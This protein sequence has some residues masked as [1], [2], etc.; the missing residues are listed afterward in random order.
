MGSKQIF[1]K[2]LGKKQEVGRAAEVRHY[3]SNDIWAELVL[4][5]GAGWHESRA[6][7]TK[8]EV[9]NAITNNVHSNIFKDATD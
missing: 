7:K 9:S 2:I 4:I 3:L 1:P 5:A 6:K 8:Y